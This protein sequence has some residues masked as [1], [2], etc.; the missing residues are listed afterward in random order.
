LVDDEE[1]SSKPAK[2]VKLDDDDEEEESEGDDDSEGDSGPDPEVAKVRFAELE[3]AWSNT[4]A[5]I[6]QYGR[7]S[8]EADALVTLQLSL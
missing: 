1:D 5:A 4:K 2:D 8:K 3:Q 6:Q 7:N